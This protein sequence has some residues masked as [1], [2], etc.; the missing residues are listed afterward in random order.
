MI[1]IRLQSIVDLITEDNNIADIGSDHGYVLI[2]LRNKGFKSKLL[3]VENK[4]APFK[5]LE[6]GLKENNI[7]DV[8]I[9]L[10]D[11]LKEVGPEFKTIVIAGMGFDTIKKIIEE[12]KYKLENVE[13]FVIDSH[14]SFQKV[15][16]YFISL[17]YDVDDEQIIYEDSIYYQLIRF[18]KTNIKP[19]YSER[20]LTY[21]PINISKKGN[22]FIN[23]INSEIDTR[24]EILSKIPKSNKK[25][26]KLLDE[27]SKMEEL[28]WIQ[29]H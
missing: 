2:S 20:E 6:S 16:P 14:T 21:G 25:F 1:S 5:N 24:K 8:D 22:N 12:S 17:G 11:G 10:S 15:R 26:L 18:K 29:G 4:L 13:Y 3:G 7:N 23:Y 27:I 28:L 9:S 19:N